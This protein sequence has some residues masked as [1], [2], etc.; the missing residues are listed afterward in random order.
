M[1][2]GSGCPA[3]RSVSLSY[4]SLS[5]ARFSFFL[6][7]SH[8]GPEDAVGHLDQLDLGDLGCHLGAMD[9]GD[10]VWP[11]GPASMLGSRTRKVLIFFVVV[12]CM[13][14]PL[15]ESIPIIT[16]LPAAKPVACSQ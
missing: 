10:P 3:L 13:H 7:L 12:D 2:H 11:V 5:L 4:L 6:S 8:M 14:E 16:V 9:P 15:H 1:Y